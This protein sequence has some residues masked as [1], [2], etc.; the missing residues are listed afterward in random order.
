M[1]RL[2][3]N[4]KLIGGYAIYFAI[5]L[6]LYKIAFLWVYSYR[7]QEANTGDVL[8][9][10]LVGF[11]F[12]LSVI[13]MLL[14]V[15]AFLSC[16]P[17][18]NR[19]KTFTFIWG[20]FPILISVW[21]ISHLIADIVYFENANKH[22]GYEGFVFI[23]KDMGVILKSAFEQNPL[24]AVIASALILIFLPVSTVL[25]LKYNPYHY[26][27]EKWKRDSILSVVVLV[28]AIFAVRG[29]FQE[30]PLR[31]SNAIVS[32]H[33]FVNNIA[34][35]GVFTSIMDLKSQSIP[36]YLK[37]DIQDSIRTVREEISY[38]GAEFVG[39]KYPL[40][41]KQ[42]QTNNGKPPNIVLILLENWTGKFIDPISDGK[43]FDKELT[44][45]FNQLLR[46]GKFFTRFFASGGRTT[47]GMMSILTGIPD[48]PG[49]TVVRTHQVLGNFS[50]LGSIFKGLGYDTFFVTGGDL[51]FDN[52][53][54]LMPH[55]GFD[56]VMGEK[57]IA[58]LDRFKIGAWGYDDADV[59][60]VL[61]EQISKSKKPFLG[62]SLTLSTHYPYRAPDPKFRIFKETERDF[63]YLNVYHYAD[64]AI[65]DFMDRAEKSKYF[66][67]TIFVFVADHTHHR[68]LDYYEDRNIPFLIYAPGRIKPGFD[69]KDASQLDVI[70]TILGLV[71]KET[72]FSAMGRDLLAPKKTESAY[73]AYGNLI[74]WIESDLF[75][76]HFVD[77]N[78]N[79]KYS[80]NGP[81]MEVDLCDK[82]QKICDKHFHKARAFFNLSHDLM[83][84]NLV[85]PTPQELEKKEF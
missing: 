63:E 47:N 67:N 19:F 30:T 69:D 39:K 70:P 8:F 12:D 15:F 80:A 29:G 14:G 31:A 73:F 6:I 38:E 17:Y 28:I 9:A 1:K 4:L 27:S 16:L 7:L 76:I 71:G 61:H 62:V 33:S 52:K 75:Y 77:G 34:L 10:I 85:F 72:Y 54:T 42:K 37:S 55:W 58:K 83:N 32:G 79:L 21:M 46:K 11:R 64:W 68:Y 60:Q 59:L 18:L 81:R 35:N 48:R 45:N 51:S 50:G 36:N 22:I 2:P 56:T 41:R 13:A 26:E 53:A 57:E 84:K 44:P 23:G 43:V 24:L 65:R 49:L 5:V 74:G 82:D 25:F 3:T 66:D 40:L 78:R 20:Y